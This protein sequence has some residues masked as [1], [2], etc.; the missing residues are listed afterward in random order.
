MMARSVL[1][2]VCSDGRTVGKIERHNATLFNRLE[3]ELLEHDVHRIGLVRRLAR[4]IVKAD[5]QA[6][7]VALSRSVCSESA[8]ASAHAHTHTHTHTLVQAIAL[9]L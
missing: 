8:S 4:S 9:Y 1:A 6:V 7:V 2:F 5:D 3:D